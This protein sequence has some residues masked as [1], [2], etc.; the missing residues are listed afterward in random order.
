M[1]FPFACTDK[2]RLCEE[3]KKELTVQIVG[4][5]KLMASD[6]DYVAGEAYEVLSKVNINVF[7]RILWDDDNGC[8]FL[9][10]PRTCAVPD[11]VTIHHNI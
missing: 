10:T 7:I 11:R 8:M 5:N 3:A 1:L 4:I 9:M 2:D 6:P